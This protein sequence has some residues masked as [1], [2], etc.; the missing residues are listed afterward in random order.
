MSLRSR[1]CCRCGVSYPAT[2][3]F[4][5][6]RKNRP[7][8][9]RYSCKVCDNQYNKVYNNLHKTEA[10]LYNKAHHLQKF[11]GLTIEEHSKLFNE[12]N[13][14]CA[15]CSRE[16]ELYVD[17]C[18]ITGIVRGLLCSKCNFGLGQFQ[19]KIELLKKAIKYLGV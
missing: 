12:Q 17:H 7:S 9:L 2:T 10:A 3:E 19:D 6:A 4:F 11:Y 15:I 1:T 18:H 13:G 16:T 5:Y 8:G 14:K